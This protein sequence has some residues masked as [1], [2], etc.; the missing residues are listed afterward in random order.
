MIR[1]L[2]ALA[3][4]AAL[5][6]TAAAQSLNYNYVEGGYVATNIDNGNND[7]DAD[8]FGVNAS[9]AVS[10]TFHLFGGFMV[11]ESD[12]FDFLG[13]RVR[14]DVNQWRAGIGYNMAIADNTDLL[15]RVAYE[16]VEVD[17]ISIGGQ[18]FDVDAGDNGYSLE[19]GVRSALTANL[20]GYALAGYEDFGRNADDFY[21]RLGAQYKFNPRWGISGDV[22]FSDGDSQWFVGPRFSW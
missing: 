7:I 17:S 19:V 5:P 16:K 3:L 20:E 14:T 21:G 4:V 8:G 22:K 10:P 6:A 12:R 15:A 18:R 13:S 2:L 9:V 1:P 11:Q